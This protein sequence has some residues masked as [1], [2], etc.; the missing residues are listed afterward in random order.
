MIKEC[1]ECGE[2]NELD[3]EIWCYTC[4]KCGEIVD[5]REEPVDMTWEDFIKEKYG[6][7]RGTPN[8]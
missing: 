8:E 3:E 6:E 7:E 5:I 1:P 4:V 2:E